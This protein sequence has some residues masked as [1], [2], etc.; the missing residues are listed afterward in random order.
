MVTGTSVSNSKEALRLSRLYPDYLF[1]TAGMKI[2]HNFIVELVE[3]V[4]VFRHSSSRRQ[5][6]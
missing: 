5:T 2:G 1:Y 3:N 4:F 6:F